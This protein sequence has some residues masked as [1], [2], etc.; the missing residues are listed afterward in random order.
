VGLDFGP[1]ENVGLLD[2]DDGQVCADSIDFPGLV[3]TDLG[4]HGKVGDV[5]GIDIVV[6]GSVLV[7]QTIEAEDFFSGHRLGRDVARRDVGLYAQDVGHE[8]F[9]SEICIGKK[10]IPKKF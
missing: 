2:D 7:V 10:N 4:R 9:L 5:A 1:F 6:E 3:F 8:F